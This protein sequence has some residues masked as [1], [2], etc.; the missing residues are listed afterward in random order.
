VKVWAFRYLLHESYL[1][2]V[3]GMDMLGSGMAVVLAL[4]SF[5]WFSLRIRLC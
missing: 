5:C 3:A 1:F 4:L 2:S